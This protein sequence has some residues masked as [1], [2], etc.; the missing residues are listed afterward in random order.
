MMAAHE[1]VVTERNASGSVFTCTAD[2]CGR[3]VVLHPGG[4]RTVVRRG[5]ELA[6]HHGGFGIVVGASAG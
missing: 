4:G 2:G 5:D 6:G 1:M 3:T